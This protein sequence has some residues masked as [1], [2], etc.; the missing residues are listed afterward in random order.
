M[1]NILIILCL[2]FFS[3]FLFAQTNEF[4]KKYIYEFRDGTVIIGIFDRELEGNI[5]IKDEN[6]KEIYIPSVMIAQQFEAN[7][8]NIKNGEYWFPNLHDTRYF[9]APSAFGLEKGEG[10]FGHSYWLLW[11]IQYGITDNFSIGGGATLFGLPSSLNGK[12]SFN[13][14]DDVNAALGYFWVG[15]LFNILG[16]EKSFVNMPYAVLTKGSKENNITLGIG[17]NIADSWIE[18]EDEIGPIDRVTVNM[19]GTFRASRR[20]SFIFEGWLFDVNNE[21]PVLLGGPGIRYFRKVN[22][23]TPKNGAGAKTFDFQLLTSPDLNGS[24]IPMFG[25]SQKF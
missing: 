18:F 11:Q 10:Y 5:Y 24:V 15:D 12:Y 16:D 22:R 25:A 8:K 14:Q 6:G 23:V 9:F 19:G 1:K 7:D 2:F 21:N 13:I 3:N 4:G 20:F 17:Y